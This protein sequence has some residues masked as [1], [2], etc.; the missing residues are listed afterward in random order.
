MRQRL[1]VQIEGD[2]WRQPRYAGR[3]QVGRGRRHTA[4]VDSVLARAAAPGGNAGKLDQVVLKIGDTQI[5]H[6]LPGE[7][8]NGD[9]HVLQRGG[10]FGRRDNDLFYLSGFLTGRITGHHRGHGCDHSLADFVAFEMQGHSPILLDLK[11]SD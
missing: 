11:L 8:L 10:S 2:V 4:N 1:L 3:G 7:R 6:G 9:R 5:V